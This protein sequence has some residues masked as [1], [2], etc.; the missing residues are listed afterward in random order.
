MNKPVNISYEDLTKT[1]TMFWIDKNLEESMSAEVAE[2]VAVM[3]AKLTQIETPEG[4]KAYI[5]SDKDSLSNI[6]S[7]LE[8]SEEKF[9]RIIS[10]LRRER[11]FVFSTEWSLDKTRSVLIDNTSFMDDVC[12]LLT[13]GA[14]SDRFKRKIPD[15][16]RDSFRI[17]KKALSRLTDAGELTRMV[18]RQLDVKYNNSVANI[19]LRKIEDAV[20]LT[21]DTEGVTYVKNK[22]VECLGKTFNFAIPDA[23]N[24]R[25]IIDCS[26]NI[27]TSSTQTK[28]ADKTEDTRKEIASTGRPIVTVNILEGSGWIGRQSDYK[29][30]YENSEYTLNIA[31]IGMLDQIIRYALED[32]NNDCC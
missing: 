13:N 32:K 12:E 14:D 20:K 3:Q 28:Y 4:L 18:K 9:K 29:R 1:I 8:I 23:K 6:L 27:T 15:F 5:I 22:S 25:I 26:Y 10:M 2:R 24:P 11:R 21:C 17:D 16:Y 7:L 31:N 30:I 19:V